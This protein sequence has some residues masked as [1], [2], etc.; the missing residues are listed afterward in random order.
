MHCVHFY[1]FKF[2][3]THKNPQSSDNPNRGSLKALVRIV[4][5]LLLFLNV[6]KLIDIVILFL[7]IGI[8]IQ[9]NIIEY[10]SLYYYL[11]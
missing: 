6:S 2:S 1:T 11:L 7:T 8:A 9:S 4:D 10:C 3:Q 5:I